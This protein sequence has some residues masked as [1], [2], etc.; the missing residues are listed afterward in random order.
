MLAS[1]VLYIAQRIILN[2]KYVRAYLEEWSEE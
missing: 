2:A 1:V